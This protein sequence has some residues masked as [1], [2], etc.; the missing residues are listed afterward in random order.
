MTYSALLI[1][2]VCSSCIIGVIGTR[3]I[4]SSES[5]VSVPLATS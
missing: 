5:N 1:S 4:L 2:L 3:N